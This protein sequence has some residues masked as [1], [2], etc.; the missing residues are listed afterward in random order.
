MRGQEDAAK[1]LV[2]ADGVVTHTVLKT[3]RKYYV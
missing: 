3:V 1:P 2:R